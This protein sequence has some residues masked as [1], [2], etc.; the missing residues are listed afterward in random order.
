MSVA[1][2]GAAPPRSSVLLAHRWTA[3]SAGTSEIA[4]TSLAL[5]VMQSCF[6]MIVAAW[7]PF[8]GTTKAA[9]GRSVTRPYCTQSSTS[10]A[11]ESCRSSSNRASRPNVRSLGIPS[12]GDFTCSDS[13]DVDG[14][15]GR[16]RL[17]PTLKQSTMW[18]PSASVAAAP[19]WR[20]LPPGR[21]AARSAVLINDDKP[22]CSIE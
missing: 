12:C 22:T 11:D 14:M 13:K 20:D 15:E 6:G 17:P 5:S 8:E 18:A 3:V 19:V 1:S 10:G 7:R 2:E 21:M 16:A 9:E 4:E